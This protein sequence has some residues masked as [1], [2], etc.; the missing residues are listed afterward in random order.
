M[1]SQTKY[2]CNVRLLKAEFK[3]IY[4]LE[5]GFLVNHVSILYRRDLVFWN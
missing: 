1:K 2:R 4:V 5:V 3:I